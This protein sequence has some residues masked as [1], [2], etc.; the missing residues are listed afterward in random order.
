MLLL[1]ALLMASMN[2][3][4]ILKYY[5]KPS[6]IGRNFALSTHENA[7][8]LLVAGCFQF[9]FS[10]LQADICVHFRA[11]IV[12]L[13]PKKRVQERISRIST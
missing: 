8:N 10:G 2:C 3:L 1:Y 6:V 13:K 4:L 5:E 11:I 12:T 7:P 9:D